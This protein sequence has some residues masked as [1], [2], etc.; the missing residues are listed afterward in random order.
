MPATAT[1]HPDPTRWL[2]A[3]LAVT[4]PLGALA[5]A[6]SR[7]IAPYEPDASAATMLQEISAHTGSAD[8][9]AWLRLVATLFL[10]PGVVVTGLVA[11]RRAPRLAT[12]A[13]FIGVPAWSAA[14]AFPDTDGLAQAI[15]A[16]GADPADG[17]RLLDHLSSFTGSAASAAVA[18]F[19]FGHLVATVIAGIALVRARVTPRLVA[20]GLAISQPAH[21]VA[22]VVLGSRVLDA[23]AYG[24]TAL[25]FGAAGYAFWRGRD[26]RTV[27]APTPAGTASSAGGAVPAASPR[28]RTRA[29]LGSAALPLAL[30][31]AACGED[32]LSRSEFIEQANGVCVQ[33]S[34]HIA[35]LFAQASAGGEPGPQEMQTALDGTV[36]ASRAAI[37]ALRQLEEPA[38]L[39]ADVD[40]LLTEATEAT[41]TMQSQGLAYFDSDDNPW[42]PMNDAAR[43]IGLDACVNDG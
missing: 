37:E 30:A 19:V 1:P 7:L 39:S 5:I 27:P 23:A 35:S 13:L 28:I 21:F 24:L 22:F 34:A 4:A 16:T 42:A 20:V 29:L 25:G 12:A 40:R 3:A 32:R 11:L 36:R 2:R 17:A 10:L 18:L 43:A 26:G 8:A 38:E 31:T 6:A 9:L 41:D 33:N 15:G 14:L